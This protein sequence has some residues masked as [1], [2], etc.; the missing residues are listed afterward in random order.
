MILT[1]LNIQVAIIKAFY[2][3][4]KK[5][6]KYYTG[7]AFGK[8]NTCLFKEIRLL[9]AYVEI[10]RNFEIVG[11]TITCNCCVDGEYTVLLNELTEFSE[12][13]IQFNCDGTG[14][15]FFDNQQYPFTY[16]YSNVTSTLIIRFDAL[17]SNPP[18]DDENTIL[19]L[20]DLTFQADCSFEPNTVS[21]IE[22]ATTIPVIGTP[23][24]TN[25]VNILGDEVFDWDGEIF[26]TDETLTPATQNVPVEDLTS[27]T[28]IVDNWNAEWHPTNNGWLLNYS[29][30]TQSYTMLSLFDGVNYANTYALIF[31]QYENGNDSNITFEDVINTPWVTE[32]SL[33]YTELDIP[34]TFV[35][36]HAASTTIIPQ[37]TYSFVDTP[38]PATTTL[39][40]PTDIFDNPGAKATVIYNVE[41]T[42]FKCS[43]N[44]NKISNGTNNGSINWQIFPTATN[45]DFLDIESTITYINNHLFLGFEVQLLSTTI[46]TYQ[47]VNSATALI[48]S[49]S[50]YSFI[51]DDVV[52][53]KIY[54]NYYLTNETIG[55]YTVQLGDTNADVVNGLIAAVEAQADFEGTI[56][57]NVNNYLYLTAPAGTGSDWNRIYA[58]SLEN[59]SIN[60]ATVYFD[61]GNNLTENVYTL[62]SVAPVVGDFYN[63]YRS[64]TVNGGG[65]SYFSGGINNSQQVSV[66]VNVDST[67]IYSIEP[68][69]FTSIDDFITAFNAAGD[70]QAANIGTTGAYTQVE[71]TAPL[72]NTSNV[73]Y[74]NQ[75]VSF[76]YDKVASASNTYSGGIDTTEGSYTLWIYNPSG[77]PVL[78]LETASP[79]NYVDL[80]DLVDNINNNVDNS[81]FIASIVDN[82]IVLTSIV[83]TSFYNTYYA[84]LEYYYVSEAYLDYQ[85]D[86]AYFLGGVDQVSNPFTLVDTINNTIFSQTLDSYSYNDVT[87]FTVDF[88]DNNGLGYIAQVVSDGPTIPGILAQAGGAINVSSV[89]GGDA[90]YIQIGY[91]YVGDTYYVPKTLPSSTV[92]LTELNDIINNA[93]NYTGSSVLTP[94]SITPTGL[95]VT[96]PPNTYDAYN[97][98]YMYITKI[99]YIAAQAS[100]Q[101]S[102][103]AVAGDSFY[104]YVDGYNSFPT[105]TAATN[106]TVG[107][108]SSEYA[109][110]INSSGSEFTAVSPSPGILIVVA[111]L[112]TGINMNNV[113]TNYVAIIDTGIDVINPTP[114]FGSGNTQYATIYSNPFAGGKSPVTTTTVRFIAPPQPLSL[115][116]TGTSNY[117]N[118]DETLTYNYNSGEFTPSND[119]A[120]GIDTTEGK[121][122]LQ[123]GDDPA[124]ESNITLY[125]DLVNVNYGSTQELID[126]INNATS[127][128]YDFNAELNSNNFIINSPD[129]SFNYYNNSLMELAYTYRS[130]QY[131]YSYNYD[132]QQGISDGVVGVNPNLVQYYG[133]FQNGDIGP[134]VTDNPCTPTVAEQT[135]LTNSQVNKIITHIDKLVK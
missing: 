22:V 46:Q 48:T 30:A 34:N 74:N 117:V 127:T 7:L 29:S 41:D 94:N 84:F 133:T 105:Y 75:T 60:I 58:T 40:I 107:Q 88:T 111:P 6:V 132:L 112:Y 28:T 97:G 124:T 54:S 47:T 106:K 53:L 135:C 66:D 131:Y 49:S 134:F 120:N 14:D 82:K 52:T 24:T 99:H 25:Y 108:V 89:V 56:T 90:L 18:T 71:F 50:S 96:A 31:E 87:D 3:L 4:A 103:G 129:Y 119:Y 98:V 118:N 8:N 20:Q 81:E 102:S 68:N 33:A 32:E 80:Q 17:Y 104:I 55:T 123:L 101:F 95:L 38:V 23:V 79:V 11:S 122:F 19:T 93:Y 109:A 130:P 125:E 73:I 65:W 83:E 116:F 63:T 121:L 59:N 57:T 1:P 115:P 13:R 26:V 78:I 15:M 62:A 2:A 77:T 114:Q 12:A 44:S 51:A 42:F 70:T 43:Y 91:T 113:I 5:S 16:G 39:L 27:P 126:A 64:S 10:L 35:G 128:N 67:P 100:F 45:P 92:L 110:L 9:R 21:P 37:F 85:S 72:S 76:E 69:N 86:L 36:K 61:A